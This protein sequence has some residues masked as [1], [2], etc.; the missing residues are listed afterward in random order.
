MGKVEKDLIIIKKK[1]FKHDTRDLLRKKKLVQVL[2]AFSRIK[3]DWSIT[4]FS[5]TII[6]DRKIDFKNV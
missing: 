1:S 2:L 5:G 3:L 4:S 6:F